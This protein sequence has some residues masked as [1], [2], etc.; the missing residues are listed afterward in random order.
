MAA[1]ISFCALPAP[2]FE[3][4]TYPRYRPALRGDA[5]NLLQNL[6]RHG[7]VVGLRLGGRP[8]GGGLGG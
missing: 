4:F 1:P 7:V 2:A 8:G 5:N 6:A 3:H